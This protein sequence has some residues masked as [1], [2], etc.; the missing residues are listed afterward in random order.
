MSKREVKKLLTGLLCLGGML[1]TMA[2][3]SA[4]GDDGLYDNYQAVYSPTTK[5]FST[6]L[7]A[8]DRIVLTKKVSEGTGSYS[9]YYY[10]NGKVAIN[11]NSN[12]EF[13]KDGRLIAVDNAGLKYYEVIYKNKKFIQ[14]ELTINELEKIFPYTQ[15][16]K[17]SEFKNNKITIK[18]ELFKEKNIL[19]YNDTDK[20]FHKFSYN[21][22]SVQKTDIKGLIRINH[23]G[24][25]KFS[26]Y[27][28]KDNALTIIVKLGK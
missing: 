15:I 27:E 16:V 13:I 2:I 25:I 6:G 26:H 23:I 10:S 14:K 28:D 4:Y 18:K 20:Y 1:I 19:L 17:I 3:V 21:P 24:K 8:D 7:M 9:S 12:Y 22:P 5:S 11:L